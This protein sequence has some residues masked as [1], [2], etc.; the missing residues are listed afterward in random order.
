[1]LDCQYDSATLRVNF[2]GEFANDNKPEIIR[3]LDFANIFHAEQQ[4]RGER[5]RVE[6]LKDSSVLEEEKCSPQRK[7]LISPGPDGAEV[8]NVLNNTILVMPKRS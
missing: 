1:M 5:N 6:E 2:M 8:D 7:E 3:L 4:A